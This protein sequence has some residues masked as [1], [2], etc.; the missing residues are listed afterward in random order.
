MDSFIDCIS[1]CEPITLPQLLE[2]TNDQKLQSL[3]VPCNR[4][5]FTN[6]VL[7]KS[8]LRHLAISVYGG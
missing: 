2:Q 4:M 5:I 1:Y 3:G 7:K 6:R 8:Q